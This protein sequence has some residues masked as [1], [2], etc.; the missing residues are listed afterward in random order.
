MDPSTVA[1]Q[2]QCGTRSK[3]CYGELLFYHSIEEGCDIFVCGF[4][5]KNTA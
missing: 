4:C 3:H 5:M 1:A 2:S